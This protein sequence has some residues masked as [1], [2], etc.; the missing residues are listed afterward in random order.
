MKTLKNRFNKGNLRSR[1]MT[2][3]LVLLVAV[4][5]VISAT[6]IFI[7]KLSTKNREKMINVMDKQIVDVYSSQ[8]KIMDMLASSIANSSILSDYAANNYYKSNPSR[9]PKDVSY[10]LKM[11]VGTNDLIEEVLIYDY[12]QEY[13]LRDQASF[14]IPYSYVKLPWFFDAKGKFKPWEELEKHRILTLSEG[15]ISFTY[16]A[17]LLNKDLPKGLYI[18]FNLSKDKVAQ[19]LQEISLTANTKNVLVSKEDFL[20]YPDYKDEMALHLKVFTQRNYDK[21]SKEEVVDFEYNY[22]WYYLHMR[23][24]DL[25][26]EVFLM[27]VIPFKDFSAKIYEYATLISLTLAILV[28]ASGY[29]I[30]SKI[31]SVNIQEPISSLVAGMEKVGSGDF[32]SKLDARGCKDN[33]IKELFCAY[34]L[35]TDRVTVLIE[36]LYQAE[37][38]RKQLELQSLQDKIN[39][40][41]LYNTLDTI[42]WVAKEHDVDEISKIVV[43]LSTMYRKVFNKGRDLTTFKD[44][45]EGIACYLDIQ[46]IRYGE[47]F[48]YEISCPSDLEKCV[49]L[50]LIIQTIVENAIVH[51]LEDQDAG[52]LSICVEKENDDIIVKVTDNGIGMTEEK[53]NLINASINSVRLESESGLRN[54]QK[55]IKLYYGPEYG[56]EIESKHKEGTSVT[57]RVPYR[58]EE[59]END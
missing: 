27:Y 15:H 1:M 33:E 55:R 45:L 58:L 16:K 41:F 5:L 24:L 54:V 36:E 18:S 20:F 44:A 21:L 28:L 30:F 2:I 42:N 51:G 37:L 43:S 39:P 57:I 32:S 22:S 40:H 12:D 3:F 53:L 49:I 4:L 29:L 7:V 50:N 56:I 19:L 17:D 10:F 11:A 48:S 31:I 47:S 34:N 46:R 26:K 25:D 52:K 23:A 38:Y 6:N 13:L 35:M 8:V 14:A 59:Q 9:S